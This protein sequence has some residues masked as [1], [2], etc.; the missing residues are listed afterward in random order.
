LFELF[1]RRQKAQ[2]LESGKIIFLIHSGTM[3]SKN[4]AAWLQKMPF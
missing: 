1:C 2:V 4:D 3:A